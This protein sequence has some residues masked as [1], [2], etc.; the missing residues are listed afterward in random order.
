MSI[1]N[2]RQIARVTCIAAVAAVSGCHRVPGL[3][4]SPGEPPAVTGEA[5]QRGDSLFNHGSCIRC[6][7]AQGVGGP[8][9]P[10]L[11]DDKWIHIDG[12]Y[13]AIVQLVTTGFTKSEQVDKQYPFTM[14]PRG[15]TH[16]TDAQIRDIAAYV[17]TLSRPPRGG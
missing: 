4:S 6:H 3:V 15:G 10:S 11:I 13:D 1:E 12:S 7:G 17:W 9:A 8:R 14:N 16:L 2:V 5:V